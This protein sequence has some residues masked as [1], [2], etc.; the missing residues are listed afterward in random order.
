MNTRAL[1][2]ALTLVTTAFVGSFASAQVSVGNDRIAQGDYAGAVEAFETAVE[3]NDRSAYAWLLLARA[4]TYLADTLPES[5]ADAR[6]ALYEDALEAAEQAVALDANEADAHMEVARAAGR[7]AQFQG[8]LNSINLAGVVK[9]ALDRTLELEPD[10]GPALHA[11]GLF[12]H[13]VPWI[14]GGRSRQVVP[15]FEAAIAA[16]PARI[17]H[18][19]ELAKI[20]IER[21]DTPAAREQLEVAV[22]LEAV[23]AADEADR[24]EAESLLASLP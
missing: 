14:A 21:E 24:A 10:H 17:T 6:Q 22:E 18:R 13:E 15:S 8:V 23:S 4:Q 1:F 19:V 5:D 2:V 11:L 3:R 16:E 7:N 20:L 9:D 12:H